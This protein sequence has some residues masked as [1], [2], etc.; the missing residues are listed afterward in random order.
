MLQ[1]FYT[2]QYFGTPAGLPGLKFTN[3]GPD[4]LHG[5]VCQCAKF[6]LI[7]TT[8]I[9]DICCQSSPI[10]LMA[11]TKKTG[12]RHTMQR[13]Q[14]NRKCTKIIFVTYVHNAILVKFLNAAHSNPQ[15]Q[16]QL[17]RFE[18]WK[19][20][21]HHNSFTALLPGPPGWA[22]AR[23][24]LLDFMVQGKINR[25]RHTDHPAGWHSIRTNQCPPPPSHYIFYR[26]DALPAAQPTASKH[27]RQRKKIVS[28]IQSV[29]TCRLNWQYF[30]H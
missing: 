18:M 11:W 25:G 17:I 23:R 26:P 15:Y 29:H 3:L 30:V 16:C 7:L 9:Q 27:W 12:K 5:Q 10:S 1:F 2:L 4:V 28:S 21:H 24:E 8:C 6:R 20:C 13:Q 19:N 22:G 14:T